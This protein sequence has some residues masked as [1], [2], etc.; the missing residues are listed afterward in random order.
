MMAAVIPVIDFKIKVSWQTDCGVSLA[1]KWKGTRRSRDRA[2]G[3]GC[4]RAATE[5]RDN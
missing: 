2:L 1:W 5:H 3:P 4:H